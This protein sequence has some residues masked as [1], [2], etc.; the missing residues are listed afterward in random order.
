[1]RLLGYVPVCAVPPTSQTGITT[2]AHRGAGVFETYQSA[3]VAS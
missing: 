1:M 3:Y 2:P